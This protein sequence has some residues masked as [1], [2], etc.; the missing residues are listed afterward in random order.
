MPDYQ[1]R[2]RAIHT[3]SPVAGAFLGFRVPQAASLQEI[4]YDESDNKYRIDRIEFCR[5]NALVDGDTSDCG[6]EMQAV[7][8][9]ECLGALVPHWETATTAAESFNLSSDTIKRSVSVASCWYR[10][11]NTALPNRSTIRL[12]INA[13]GELKLHQGAVYIGQGSNTVIPQI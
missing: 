6:Q 1:A 12:G 2:D 9:R 10:L 11:G 3:N 7:G 5:M 4:L 13:K 8:I